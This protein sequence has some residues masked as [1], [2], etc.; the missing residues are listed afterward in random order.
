MPVV[1]SCIFGVRYRVP[2]DLP[3]LIASGLVWH[4][5]VP[6]EYKVLA[7]RALLADPS[8]VNDRV[9]SNVL[10]AL[11]RAGVNRRG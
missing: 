6:A 3:A 9:P 2:R 5:N 7:L 4:S 8:L 10:A 11:R 1:R